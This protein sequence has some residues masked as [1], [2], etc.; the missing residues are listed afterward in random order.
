EDAGQAGWLRP[1]SRTWRES[2]LQGPHEVAVPV[3]AARQGLTQRVQAHGAQAERPGVEVLEA[4][5]TSG[6]GFGFFPGLEPDSLAEL[7]G[8]DLPRPAEV[9]VQ[10][11]VQPLLVP[12]GVGPQELPGDLSVPALAL[13]PAGALGISSSRCTPMSRA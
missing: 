10:F 7:V 4:E 3:L 1:V 11:E 8:R 2:G 12:A 13:P 9:A 5:G 6:P